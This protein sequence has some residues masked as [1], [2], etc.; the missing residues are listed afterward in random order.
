MVLG[1][2]IMK[3]RMGNMSDSTDNNYNKCYLVVCG[4]EKGVCQ[5]H[6]TVHHK[7]C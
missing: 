3:M 7:Y 2:I 6:G 4:F 1:Q 5:R